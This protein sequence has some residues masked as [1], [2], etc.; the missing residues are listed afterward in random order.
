MHKRSPCF[1]LQ[2]ILSVL[3][4]HQNFSVPVIQLQQL[5]SLLYVH[6][7]LVVSDSILSLLFE[8]TKSRLFSSFHF[9]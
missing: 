2:L 8:E 3:C 1:H 4:S 9:A 6:L 7:E 5:A